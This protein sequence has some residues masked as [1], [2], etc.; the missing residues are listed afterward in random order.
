[1][2]NITDMDKACDFN[3]GDRVTIT[4][5]FY[6]T[7]KGAVVIGR[8]LAPFPWNGWVLQ[9]DGKTDTVVYR[10]GDFTKD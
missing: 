10:S 1:M 7:G 3:P 2:I 9:I 5:P 6:D 4:N 8:Y